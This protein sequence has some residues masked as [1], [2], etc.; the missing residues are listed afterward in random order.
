MVRELG[1][2]GGLSIVLEAGG[3]P[4]HW[5]TSPWPFTWGGGLPCWKLSAS[6]L[7]GEEMRGGRGKQP[8]VCQRIP[9]MS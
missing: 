6:A 1:W 9:S 2:G 3:S 5:V 8:L 4:P 7:G